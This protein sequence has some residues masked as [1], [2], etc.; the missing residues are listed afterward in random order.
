MELVDVIDAWIAQGGEGSYGPGGSY[1]SLQV[2][3]SVVAPVGGYVSRSS[4]YFDIFASIRPD[5]DAKLQ[6]EPEGRYVVETRKLYTRTADVSP[7]V[8][9][10]PASGGAHDADVV[11]LYPVASQ[12]SLGDFCASVDAVLAS[13][14]VGKDGNAVTLQLEADGSGAGSLD[15]TAWP[16]LVFHYEPAVTT[17]ADLVAAAQD[18]TKLSVVD[19]GTGVNVFTS[20]DAQTLQLVGG[21]GEEWRV[22]ACSRYRGFWKATIERLERP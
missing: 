22:I 19:I 16:A 13:A 1:P 21:D 3:R 18:G 7:S 5:G 10:T 20:D 6:D 9:D 11:T 14:I 12:I 8:G 15:E 2:T 17:D 4:S